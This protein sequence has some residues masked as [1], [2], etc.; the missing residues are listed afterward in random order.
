MPLPNS[1][2]EL[3]KNAPAQPK[4]YSSMEDMAPY[5]MPPGVPSNLSDEQIKNAFL[6]NFPAPIQEPSPTQNYAI[7]E[8]ELGDVQPRNP[9]P[10]NQPNYDAGLNDL[11]KQIMGAGASGISQQEDYLQKLKDYRNKLE[12]LPQERD[13]TAL[14]M[15]SDAWGGTNFQSKY[16]KPTS[17][18]ERLKQIAG[19]DAVVQQGLG[20]L[21]DDQIN[22]LTTKFNALR[23]LQKDKADADKQSLTKGQEKLDQE[24]SKTY[25]EDFVSGKIYKAINDVRG[26]S[27]AVKA[28]RTEKDLTG[29]SYGATPEFLRS[30]IHPRSAEIQQNVERVIQESLRPILGAQFTKDEGENLLKRTY[31]PAL[32]PE[33]NAARVE[34]LVNQLEKAAETKMKAAKHFEK[35]GTLNGLGLSSFADLENQLKEDV[36]NSVGGDLPD[37][38]SNSGGLT[39]DE[40]AE[41]EALEKKYGR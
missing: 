5:S 39:E 4:N 30:Y 27:G 25:N 15:A 3:L 13:Y 35:Y 1:W 7:N 2:M 26:L 17:P 23:G 38:N 12:G 40:K 31:N 22:L 6:D 10:M 34:N 37:G 24:F 18:E 14:M 8:Q 19:A 41:L 11:Y 36:L 20:G 28:L 16:K 29:K 32:P 9:A 21:T 33:V